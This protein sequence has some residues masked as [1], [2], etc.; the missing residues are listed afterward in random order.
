[1]SVDSQR[2]SKRNFRYLRFFNTHCSLVEIT[3]PQP[4][5]QKSK[6][7]SSHSTCSCDWFLRHP[8]WCCCFCRR[9]GLL[10][11]GLTKAKASQLGFAAEGLSDA[12]KDEKECWYARVDAMCGNGNE[13]TED[14]FCQVSDS[15]MVLK[16]ICLNYRNLAVDEMIRASLLE[17]K[18]V[19]LQSQITLLQREAD[20]AR[21]QINK[22]FPKDGFSGNSP[23]QVCIF[24]DTALMIAGN[25][26]LKKG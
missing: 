19:M 14:N 8:I 6:Y 24:L 11:Q 7:V 21:Q 23:V 16:Q 20:A 26:K 2:L 9:F 12:G 25:F 17:E 13:K 5:E 1:M 15:I 3:K 4:C 18:N 22:F 10:S